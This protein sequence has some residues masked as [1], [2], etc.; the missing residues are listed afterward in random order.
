MICQAQYG[1]LPGATSGKIYICSCCKNPIRVCHV[2]VL[3]PWLFQGVTKTSRKD[4]LAAKFVE[5][6]FE[7][8]DRLME[9]AFRWGEL[10]PPHT[11]VA[12]VPNSCSALLLPGN[13]HAHM[14]PVSNKASQ[15]I[16]TATGRGC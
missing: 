7:K 14:H 1:G 4:R 5:A 13:T 10:G 12:S 11:H 3:L 6:E 15:P 2:C 8:V 9:I 16:G